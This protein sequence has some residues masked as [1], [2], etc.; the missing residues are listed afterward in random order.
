MKRIRELKEEHEPDYA[1]HHML[2]EDFS[3][4]LVHFQGGVLSTY[5]GLVAGAS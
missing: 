5:R 4:V 1:G 3:A 2:R